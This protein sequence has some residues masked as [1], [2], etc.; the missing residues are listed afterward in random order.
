VSSTHALILFDIDGTLLR[1]G[2]RAHSAAFAHAFERV[3]QRPVTLEG[4][5]MAGMLD[6]NIARVLFERHGLD[7]SEA[8]ARLHELMAA[9]GERYV[10][11]TIDRDT[12]EWLLP[13]VTEAVLAC[14]A[15]GWATG[16]LTGNAE[17]VGRAKLRAAGF[18]QLLT[19]GAWGDTAAERGHLVDT[20]IIAAE[21]ATGTRYAPSQT[22]LIGDTPQDINA[23][24]LGGAKVLGVATGRFDVATLRD[25]G[26][27]AVLPDL[28]DTQAFLRELDALVT[29]QYILKDGD[30]SS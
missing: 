30:P 20:A 13:G 27:D 29:S 4:V 2:D 26:A 14:Q 22:V 9:M 6:A 1:A 19:Y 23:A 10:E 15:R 18:S 24:R 11:T 28:S 12:R 7:R 8:D 3:Y 5:P 21:A 25:H 16:V 17:V